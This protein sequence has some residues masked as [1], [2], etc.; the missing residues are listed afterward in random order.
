ML[1]N[2]STASRL[3]ALSRTLARGYKLTVKILLSD[4]EH[5]NI[6]ERD[7]ISFSLLNDCH[8]LHVIANSLVL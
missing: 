2:I 4:F 8:L 3:P 7:V 1:N 6:A 5:R